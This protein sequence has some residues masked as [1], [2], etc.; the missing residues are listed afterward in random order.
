MKKIYSFVLMAAMLLIGTNVNA[1][2][3]TINNDNVA[4]FDDLLAAAHDGDVFNVVTPLQCEEQLELN[5]ENGGKV[6]L[7]LGG[8]VLTMTKNV[9]S[10]NAAIIVR[11]GTLEIQNGTIQASGTCYDLIRVIGSNNAAIDAANQTPYSQLIVNSGVTINSESQK[12]ALTIVEHATKVNDLSYANGARIDVYGDVAARKY[13][14]KVNGSIKMPEGHPEY[15]PY[16]YIHAGANVSTSNTSSDAVAAYSSGYGRWRIEGNC[17]GN[18]GLYAKGGDIDIVGNATITSESSETSAATTGKTSGVDAGGSAIV[19]ESNAAYPGN[20]SVTISDNATIQGD[21]GY[22]IEE[23]VADAVEG[24]M[25][26]SVSIEGGNINGG[27][28]GAVIIDADTKGAGVVSVVGGTVDGDVNVGDAEEEASSYQTIDLDAL[29]PGSTNNNVEEG[30]EPDY[31]VTP[32]TDGI[33]V[34]PNTAKNVTLNDKGWASYSF[35]SASVA[36]R[37]VPSG[38]TAYI[39]TVVENDQLTLSP[40][41]GTIPSGVGV[42]LHGDL[43]AT[44]TMP[45]TNTA[46]TADFDANKLQPSTEFDTDK[47]ANKNIYILHGEEIWLYTGD[48]FKANKAYLPYAGAASSFG[49][50]ARIQMVIAETQDIE[51]VEFEAVKAVKFIENGQVLI[52]R[53]EKVYNVQGQIVK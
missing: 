47:A 37:A 53:G 21:G 34:E 50:P 39:G 3:I 29:V 51:N 52:K 19:I 7:N 14:I 46:A 24:T 27:S 6:V 18:T 32:V 11:K 16:V 30:K 48:V 1:A 12:N 41:S 17:T 8:S 43:N 15:S 5:L 31:Q 26:S 25:V 35:E 38:V 22:A 13:G 36:Y 40:V 20:I 33:K 49:A 44:F 45:L 9:G 42:I 28:A 23:T 4:Q 10:S 2:T